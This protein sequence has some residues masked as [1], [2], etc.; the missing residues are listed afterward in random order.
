MYNHDNKG[1]RVAILDLY[2]G[3]PNQGMRCLKDILNQYGEKHGIEVVWNVY[4]V[5]GARQVPDL[6]YDVYLSS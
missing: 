5:R 2:D 6:S 1:I 3:Q 4:D